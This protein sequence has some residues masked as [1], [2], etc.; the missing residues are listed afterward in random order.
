MKTATRF[1]GGRMHLKVLL[2]DQIGRDGYD[3]AEPRQLDQQ[4]GRQFPIG[5]RPGHRGRDNPGLASVGEFALNVFGFTQRVRQ[6][7]QKTLSI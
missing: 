2:Q 6:S 7:G 5:H 1:L 3:S 4:E